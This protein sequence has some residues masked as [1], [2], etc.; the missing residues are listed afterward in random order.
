M[1]WLNGCNPIKLL[2][3]S[4]NYR[5]AAYS[6]LANVA[7]KILS[8]FVLYAS[9]PRTIDYLGP[10]RFGIWMTLAS[11]IG[12][13]GFLDFGIGN[14]LLNQ[15]AYLAAS[16]TRGRLR[17]LIGHALLLLAGIGLSL[18][19]LLSCIARYAH[20]EFLFNI[21]DPV[22]V[23]ELTKAAMTLAV[24]IGLS[25]P[26][27]G[28][29]RVFWGLQQ[30]FVSHLFSAVGSGVSVILLFVLSNR[31]APIY[32][33]LLGTY[34]VQLLMALPLLAVLF[35]DRLIGAI[36]WAELREDARELL[37]SGSLFFV[38]N[39]G[40]AV[41]W[42]GDYLILSRMAGAQHVAVFA[43]AVRLFQLVSQPLAMINSPLW[44]AYADAIAR[45]NY[46]FVRKT[47][48]G[49]ISLT[50]AGAM[51]G[52]SVLV[53]FHDLIIRVWIHN[54]VDVPRDLLIAM[55]G[56]TVIQST[57]NAFAM[58]MNG[59][60]VVRPQV[61]VVCLFCIAALPLKILAAGRFGELG[62]VVVSLISYVVCVV[63]PYL[64]VFRRAWVLRVTGK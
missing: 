59:A 10:E 35:K 25:L 21:T 12:L 14:G 15:V 47:L 44:S 22:S 40:A 30:A 61:V 20:L 53:S 49:A 3:K 18:V 8:L 45:G 38:L 46:Q 34:G 57:G 5:L 43:I 55:A 39:L 17:R 54:A 29:Q 7:S 42:E 9:V 28:L 31:H 11:F 16:G 60:K 48:V 27:V 19:V 13:L 56:W 2:R 62:I 26:L 52:V 51:V 64:T 50:A 41:A 36:D 23:D 32:A 63:V 1:G 6:T 24:L 58:F 4:P 33:L 37:R